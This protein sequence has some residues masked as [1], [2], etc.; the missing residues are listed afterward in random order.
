MRLLHTADLHLG[1][2][3]GRSLD[4]LDALLTAAEREDVDALTVGG[5]CFDAATAA[6]DLRPQLRERFTDNGFD[7]LVVP[8]NRDAAVFDGNVEFGPDFR[9]LTTDPVEVAT[10]GDGEVVAVPSCERLGEDRFF[11]LR[12]RAHDEAV[13]LLHCTLD[14]GFGTGGTGDEAE[15]THCPVQTETLGELGYEFVLAGHV[16]SEL[17]QRKL[18]NGGLFIY[19][20]SPVSHSWA[21][22]GRRHAVVVDTDDANV[23]PVAL[24]TFYRDRFA[25]TVA[26]GDAYDA[27]DRVEGWVDGQETDRSELE[28]RVD[29]FTELDESTFD[30]RL[31]AAAGPATVVNET[32]GVAAVLDHPIYADFADRLDDFDLDEFDRVGDPEAVEERLVETLA[33]LLAAGEVTHA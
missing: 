14:A 19:P 29:G 2:G 28:V 1:R 3:G 17:Y 24:D 33:E 9:A 7:V 15:P 13:L 8:G 10:V 5:D 18:P 32:R 12:E 21:E 23:Q 22:T 6:D 26:P 11:D 4:A 25:T 31:H 20:G 30:E 16:H 27:I